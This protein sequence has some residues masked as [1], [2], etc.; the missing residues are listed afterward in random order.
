MTE[1]K[2]FPKHYQSAHT[3]VSILKGVDCFESLMKIN[4]IFEVRAFSVVILFQQR[5]NLIV[6]IF[7]LHS[8]ISANLIWKFLVVSDSKSVFA[9]IR[10]T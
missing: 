1:T 5:F 2:T 9:L 10:C 8:V 6:D 4:N 7:R 3:T